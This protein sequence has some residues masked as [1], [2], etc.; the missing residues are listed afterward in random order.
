MGPVG[1]ADAAAYEKKVADRFQ[2]R[3]DEVVFGNT[4]FKNLGGG[5]F[6]EVSDRAGMETMWP[7]G[8]AT[9]DFDND[10][11]EDVFLPSGMG[12]PF[13]YWPN[14]LMMNKGDG[15]FVNRA[16]AEGIEP[17]PRGEFLDEPIGS[18]RA[19]RS[20]S[21][22]AVADFSGTGRLDIVTNN[23]NDRPYFFKNDFPRKNYVAFR[24][25]GT[26][27]NKDAVGALVRLYAGS[28]VMARQ[29]QAAGGYLSQSSKTLH[30][31]LGDRTAVDRVE[32]R[33]PSGRRQ[34]LERPEINRLHPITEPSDSE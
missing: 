33:W 32:V 16:R 4:L 15:T 23:F 10:G 5:R 2:I 24:L 29:V 9:G 21:C 17:P 11:F 12:Y 20:A 34:T 1:G 31:G 13:P 22:A 19:A 26:R 25:T 18:R 3:Y 27:S 30:F 8:I 28:E 7:W 14:Y 6:E